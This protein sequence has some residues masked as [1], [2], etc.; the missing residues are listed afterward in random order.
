MCF[1]FALCGYSQQKFSK[2]EI[3]EIHQLNK[4]FEGT[5]QVQVVNSRNQVALPF[6]LIKTI[7]KERKQSQ[8]VFYKIDD[9]I[10]IRI[11]PRNTINNRGFAKLEKLKYITE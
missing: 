3:S 7:E 9:N 5:Y 6:D 1:A 11:L 8:E 10:R 4:K 2:E